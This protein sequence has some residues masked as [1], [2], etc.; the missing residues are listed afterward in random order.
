[1]QI[2]DKVPR[3]CGREIRMQSGLGVVRAWVWGFTDGRDFDS[4]GWIGIDAA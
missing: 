3:F 4:V 1:V 2:D